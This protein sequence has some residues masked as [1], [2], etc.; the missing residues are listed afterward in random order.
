[1]LSSFL[2][3]MRWIIS[4]KEMRSY[5]PQNLNDTKQ[6]SLTQKI[7]VIIHI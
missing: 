2:D 6:I 1:M 7:A 4:R 5:F 3:A